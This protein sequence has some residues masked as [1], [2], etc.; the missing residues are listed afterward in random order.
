MIDQ[1]REEFAAD[2]L[3]KFSKEDAKNRMTA[4]AGMLRH[5]G[6]TLFA[7]ALQDQVDIRTPL[8]MEPTKT[9]DDL[10]LQ[11][12]RKG[13]AWAFSFMKQLPQVVI[14]F[15]ESNIHFAVLGESGMEEPIETL[16]A[17]LREETEQGL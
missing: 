4:L 1:T 10:P 3:G 9:M 12:Y 2:F 15:E 14:D 13:A 16:D 11:E 6:W 7:E 17:I 8:L 5:P